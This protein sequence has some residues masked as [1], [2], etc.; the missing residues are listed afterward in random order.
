LIFHKDS[1]EV[2][3]YMQGKIIPP[4]SWD[5]SR[6][7]QNN[8]STISFGAQG[9]EASAKRHPTIFLELRTPLSIS[10]YSQ[11]ILD[12][13]KNPLKTNL[14]MKIKMGEIFGNIKTEV[15]K[16]LFEFSSSIQRISLVRQGDTKE[17]MKF[18]MKRF[19]NLRKSER[20]EAEIQQMLR[21]NTEA[22]KVHVSQPTFG[23]AV[24]QMII[25]VT[26]PMFRDIDDNEN[27][28]PREKVLIGLEV[29]QGIININ[30][31]QQPN[32]LGR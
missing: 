5:I 14:N 8:I 12:K 9:Y 18:L 2:S 3:S 27:L 19:I 31:E 28:I 13:K 10:L 26:P 11:K 4:D 24:N 29:E 30:P 16:N 32:S 20:A 25:S 1:K 22:S 21:M 17:E 6:I 23:P 7:H 15:F